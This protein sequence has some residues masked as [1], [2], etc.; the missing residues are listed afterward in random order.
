MPLLN[1]LVPNESLICKLWRIDELE[2]IMDPNN[3]LNSEDYQIFL[4][5]KAN[6]L[7]NQF[8]ASRKLIGLINPDLRISYKENI[9]IL[10]DNRNIS[11]SH[12]DEIV[13]ILFSFLPTLTLLH[14]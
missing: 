3:E 1:D 9:P 5:R 8:L 4:K 7:R 10:S 12:S 2:N 11:I 6:H 14:F 13:T